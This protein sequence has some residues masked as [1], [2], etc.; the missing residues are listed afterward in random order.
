MKLM[1]GSLFS[2]AQ[3][4]LAAP[5]SLYTTNVAEDDAPEFNGPST[6]AVGDRVIRSS[7]H[8]V[9]EC[10]QAGVGS[11]GIVGGAPEWDFLQTRWKPVAW[12][13]PY[14]MFDGDPSTTTTR[15]GSTDMVVQFTRS[16]QSAIGLF[17]L[18]GSSVT[19]TVANGLGPVIYS[20]TVPLQVADVSD[21]MGYFFDAYLQRTEVLL[22]DL[23][24]LASQTITITVSPQGSSAAIAHVQTG[25]PFDLGDVELNGTSFGIRDY[26]KTTVDEFGAATFVRRGYAERASFKVIVPN[27]RLTRLQAALTAAR[28][29]PSIWIG[30]DDVQTYAPLFICGY[31]RDFQVNL[32]LPTRSYCSIEVEGLI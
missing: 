29:V 2:Y 32:A 26:S 30:D 21:W 5:G 10:V 3:Y 24:I 18:V 1:T 7:T 15:S 12:T 20:R 31:Y 22:Q 14:R 28:A 6:Y 8:R 13:R 23:P 25:R 17:G 11:D 4:A 19:V 27:G 16:N 9:Y